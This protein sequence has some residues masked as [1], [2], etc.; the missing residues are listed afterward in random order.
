MPTFTRYML[1]THCSLFTMKA[2]KAFMMVRFAL[3]CNN[4]CVGIRTWCTLLLVSRV[5]VLNF[6]GFFLQTM[7]AKV[8]HTI[9]NERIKWWVVLRR[10]KNKGMHAYFRIV[11]MIRWQW[12]IQCFFWYLCCSDE[13][14]YNMWPFSQKKTF[15]VLFWEMTFENNRM[16]G[17]DNN[18]FVKGYNIWLVNHK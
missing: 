5:V 13:E 16:F 18:C 15:G 3:A 4:N 2:V 7:N 9:S 10:W 6:C 17:R 14:G 11:C 12:V 1:N 8:L